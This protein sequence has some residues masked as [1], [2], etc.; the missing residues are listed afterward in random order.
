ML[1]CG[2]CGAKHIDMC[3][4]VYYKHCHN[5]GCIALAF[6]N[7]NKIPTFFV[8]NFTEPIQLSLKQLVDFC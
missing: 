3:T 2:L 7:N 5:T 8:L 1:N 4:C 6:R